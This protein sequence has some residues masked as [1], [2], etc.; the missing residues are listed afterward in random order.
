MRESVSKMRL[1]ELKR[2]QRTDALPKFL[3]SLETL[4]RY[5]EDLEQKERDELFRLTYKYQTELR[6]RDELAIKFRE[7]M[8]EI[9][10]KRA[11]NSDSQELDLFYLYVNRLIYEIGESE[12]CLA[13]LQSEVQRQKDVVIEASKKKKVLALLKSKR[14]KE[15][16]AS[17]EKQEQKEIDDLVVTRYGFENSGYQGNHDTDTR[18][19]NIKKRI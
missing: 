10:S 1:P 14:E 4:L 2:S 18:G 16:A 6:H 9:S 11:E 3:F 15:F 17:A 12:K 8:S 7:T 13:Q 19:T 5:R